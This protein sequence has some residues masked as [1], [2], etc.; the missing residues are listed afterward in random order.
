MIEQV[1]AALRDLGVE[2]A[3]LHAEHFTLATAE[4]AAA[5]AAAVAP[6]APARRR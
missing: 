3:R 2:A 1:S 6:G 4:P 5:R